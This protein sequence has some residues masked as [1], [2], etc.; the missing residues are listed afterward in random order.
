MRI[1]TNWIIIIFILFV[2][3]YYREVLFRSINS[4]MAGDQS[5][6]AKTMDIPFIYGWSFEKL[7]KLKYILTIAFTFWFMGISLLGL[8][9]TFPKTK[10]IY[11]LSGLYLI[12][13]LLMM[14]STLSL[15]FIDFAQLYPFLRLL[16][17]IIHNPIPFLLLSIC[18]YAFDKLNINNG[19]SN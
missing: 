2:S 11:I 19:L 16:I 6:Y 12:V 8:K 17:G 1:K 15:L 13:I 14:A 5:F 4:I 9:I 18:F 10:A 3:S 7:N